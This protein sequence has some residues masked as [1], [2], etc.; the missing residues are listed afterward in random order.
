MCQ[1]SRISGSLNLLEPYGP[2]QACKGIDLH[3][4]LGSAIVQKAR[5]QPSAPVTTSN[6]RFPLSCQEAR[7][8]W[9]SLFFLCRHLTEGGG[10]SVIHK[11]THSFEI[12]HIKLWLLWTVW[13]CN[14]GILVTVSE[15]LWNFL[16]VSTTFLSVAFTAVTAILYL[17]V[18][19]VFYPYFST[20][21]VSV[22]WN[23][24]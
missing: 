17:V 8:R 13:L 22:R 23:L 2:V 20:L 19:M 24:T 21:T 5:I 7:L 16:L 15:M 6:S 11:V 4:R 3:T 14:K 10:N 12:Y 1:L 18:Q 9:W